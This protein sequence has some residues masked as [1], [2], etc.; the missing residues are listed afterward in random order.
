MIKYSGQARIL[1]MNQFY[2][3]QTIP[4][5]IFVTSKK[6]TMTSINRAQFF[7]DYTER[8][9]CRKK[10][11]KGYN[12][13][14]NV[15]TA[16]RNLGVEISGFLLLHRASKINFI[17]NS[18]FLFFFLNQKSDKKCMWNQVTAIIMHMVRFHYCLLTMR[19]KW[20]SKVSDPY[21]TS[22]NY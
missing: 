9:L 16:L 12:Y 3:T 1:H 15:S 21:F 20:M 2:I 11:W 14:D 4:W 5:E 17:Y 19:F 8:N 7:W 18:F 22:R 6:K 13:F 10:I